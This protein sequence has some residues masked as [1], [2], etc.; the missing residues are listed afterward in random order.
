[1]FPGQPSH[2]MV[3]TALCRAAHQILDRPLI[4]EDPV[5]VDLIP[6]CTEQAIRDN[7][8]EHDG[9]GKGLLRAV[10]VYRSRFTEDRLAEA[11]A[12]GARQY[13]IVGAGLDTFPWRQPPFAKSMRIFFVDHP[14]TLTWSQ[15][16]FRERGL[17]VPPN[18]TFVAAD[19][20]AQELGARLDAHGFDR[21]TPTFVSVLGVTQ[22]ITWDAS[23]AL[24]SFVASL[25]AQS[26]I[27][28]SFAPSDDE[29]DPDEL[30]L[31]NWGLTV[32]A[33]T[34]EPWLT[35]L[36]APQIFGFLTARGFGEVFYLTKKRLR[37]RYFSGRTDTLKANLIDHLFAATV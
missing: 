1:M 14:S 36:S 6:D 17:P 13:V 3:R 11:A 27:V 26:E 5:A 7:P 29:L 21:A 35:R 37:E 31:R 22:Y 33:E 32:T 18:V 15:E 34:G 25:P 24:F 16:R 23:E 9:P 19:L 10:F 12:R 2:S 8:E 20:E 4:F 28:S 30:A